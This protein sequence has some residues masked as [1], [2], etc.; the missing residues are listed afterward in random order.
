MDGSKKKS[1]IAGNET[2]AG[3]GASGNEIQQIRYLLKRRAQ[4]DSRK[5]RQKMAPRDAPEASQSKSYFLFSEDL[6]SLKNEEADRPMEDETDNI[7]KKVPGH[8]IS[9]DVESQSS[10]ILLGGTSS[11]CASEE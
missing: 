5:K 9:M 8:G 1:I 10:E 4:V 3:E 7:L 11:Y 6:Q 2:D